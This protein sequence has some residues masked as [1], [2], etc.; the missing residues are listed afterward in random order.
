MDDKTRNIGEF[1]LFLGKYRML[2]KISKIGVRLLS[3]GGRGIKKYMQCL[4]LSLY[5]PVSGVMPDLSVCEDERDDKPCFFRTKQV[6]KR[7]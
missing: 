5:F 6:C 2:L 1:Q 3:L 7:E 4:S